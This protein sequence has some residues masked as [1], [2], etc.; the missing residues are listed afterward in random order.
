LNP[1][2]HKIASARVKHALDQTTAGQRKLFRLLE[3][4]GDEDS[5]EDVPPMQAEVLIKEE[6]KPEPKAASKPE[7]KAS[8]PKPEPKVVVSP[9]AKSEPP[10]EPSLFDYMMGDE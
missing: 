5:E 1:E 10:A 3:A 7:P 4:G 2:F 9:V 8:K 6:P